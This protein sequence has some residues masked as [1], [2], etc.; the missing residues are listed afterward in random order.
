MPHPGRTAP[1][2]RAGFSTIFRP[3]SDGVTGYVT[4]SHRAATPLGRLPSVA[5]RAAPRHPC[6]GPFKSISRGAIYRVKSPIQ[7]VHKAEISRA[8]AAMQEIADWLTRLGLPEYAGAFAEN[9]IDVSVLP[10]LTDRTRTRLKA[11]PK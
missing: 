3:R 9:G 4:S 5:L 2:P 6:G 8:W 7:R 11:A 1:G 10:H